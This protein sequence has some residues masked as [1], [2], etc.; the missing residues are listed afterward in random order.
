MDNEILMRILNE[1]QEMR[2]EMRGVREEQRVMREEI[3]EI[4][5][6][7]NNAKEHLEDVITMHASDSINLMERT[8]SYD[9]I[10]NGV[11]DI[12]EK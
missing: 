1:V 5:K 3:C 4:R 2:G 6:E 12:I 11:K 7:L 10:L 8:A 9:R